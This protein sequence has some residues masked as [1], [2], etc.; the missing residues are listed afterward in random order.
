MSVSM[1]TISGKCHSSNM[2]QTRRPMQP[3]RLEPTGGQSNLHLLYK[4]RSISHITTMHQPSR[5]IYR[6]KMNDSKQIAIFI[7][8]IFISS[9]FLSDWRFEQ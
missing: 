5:P 8:H 9:C 6:V 1:T 4:E 3:G 7:T 2:G